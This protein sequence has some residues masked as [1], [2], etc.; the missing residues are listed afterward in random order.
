[1][2]PYVAHFS[3]ANF[4]LHPYDVEKWAASQWNHRQLKIGRLQLD[5]WHTLKG[6]VYYNSC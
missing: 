1:M 5:L 2:A 4:E 3:Q 6:R